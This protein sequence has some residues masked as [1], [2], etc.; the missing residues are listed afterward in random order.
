MSSIKVETKK[1]ALPKKAL[2]RAQK[3]RRK[4]A[5]AAA[6]GQAEPKKTGKDAIFHTIFGNPT[7]FIMFLKD[8]VEEKWVKSLEEKH[9]LLL[10]GKYT[11]LLKGR[12]E[13]DVVYEINHPEYQG[14]FI[15]L[16][17]HQSSVD[18]MMPLRVLDYLVCIWWAWLKNRKP[19][20]NWET[21]PFKLPPIVPIVF[22]DGLE[23]WTV[24]TKFENKVAFSEDFARWI[25]KFEYLLVDLN[26]ISFEHL[27]SL[28]D[29]LA[30]CLMLDKCTSLDDFLHLL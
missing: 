19:L 14:Y 5:E 6:Q 23:N 10:P 2:S 27:E 20:L 26:T 12:R 18:H 22:F 16:T 30:L 28:E 7:Y 13:S 9:L 29:S 21:T 11:R 1:A 17:E 8:F 4:K 24:P 3:K 15:V 25:P